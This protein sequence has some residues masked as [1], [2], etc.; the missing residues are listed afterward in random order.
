MKRRDFLSRGGAGLLALS[1]ALSPMLSRFRLRSAAPWLLVP[2]DEA[3]ADHLKAYFPPCRPAG[4]KRRGC[5][6]GARPRHG[7]C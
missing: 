3:Q 7:R 5:E 2:M 6:S 1:P 4:S